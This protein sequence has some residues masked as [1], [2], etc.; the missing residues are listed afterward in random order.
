MQR[1]MIIGQPGS[2]KSTLARQ[3]GDRTGLPVYHIDHIHWTRGWVERSAPEK[4][5]MCLEVHAKESWVF[6][7]GHSVTWLDR[8]ERAEALI[9]LDIPICVR[10][11]RIM[12]RTA[13]YL[14]KSRPDLPEG[15]P[16]RVEWR[17]LLWVWQTRHSARQHCQ[18]LVQACPQDKS[19]VILR[20]N[21]EISQFLSVLS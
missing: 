5:R 15:C 10:L 12:R 4:T 6:E 9:W 18:K 1:I 3:I 7:G 8:L 14:G 16:E 17:F 2:G 11:Y 21:N 20:T 19:L 13:R